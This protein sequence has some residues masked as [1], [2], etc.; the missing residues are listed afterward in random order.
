MSPHKM[1]FMLYWL[2]IILL[3]FTHFVAKCVCRNLRTFV[4]KKITQ[5]F[6]GGKNDKYEVWVCG[7]RFSCYV[8]IWNVGSIQM[9]PSEVVK[10]L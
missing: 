10:S 7:T 5:N 9:Y 1:S 3:Q 6:L 8:G 4:E 2:Y